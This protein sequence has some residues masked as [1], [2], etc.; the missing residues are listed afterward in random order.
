MKQFKECWENLKKM[1]SGMQMSGQ[2]SFH[3]FQ[4]RVR[5][6]FLISMNLFKDHTLV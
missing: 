4:E 6:Q 3:L 2:A 5:L 1:G